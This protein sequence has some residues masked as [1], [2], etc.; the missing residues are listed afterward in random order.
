MF[1]VFMFSFMAGH[2]CSSQATEPVAVSRL[3]EL[4]EQEEGFRSKAYHDTR[5]VL[6]IGFGTNLSIGITRDEAEQL[7]ISR[8]SQTY[9][10]L[11]N[12]WP[13]YDRQPMEVQ[14]ALLDMAYQLGVVGVL[15]FHA[16]LRALEAGDYRL[17]AHGVRSSAWNH[18]TPRRAERVAEVFERAAQ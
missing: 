3:I 6:T 10:H 4:I 18:Q 12:S 13:P 7:A 8:L 5:G 17:A 15:K 14:S 2:K 11:N 9:I 1:G 16:T